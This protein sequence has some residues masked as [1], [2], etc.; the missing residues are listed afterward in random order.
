LG[1][2]LVF[3]DFTEQK[4]AQEQLRELSLLPTQNPAP[5]LRVADD[6]R[7]LYANLAALEH[8][9]DWNLSIGQPAPAEVR[10]LT[11]DALNAKHPADRDLTVG[12]RSYLISV[13]PI[14]ESRYANLYWTEVTERKKAVEA[15]RQAHG[16]LANHAVE[17]DNLVQQRT[18]KLQETVGEL[19]AFSYSIAHDM[20]GPLRAMQGFARV[21]VTDFGDRLDAEAR[22]YLQRIE[23][24]A[25]RMDRLITDILNYSKVV[26]GTLELK[27][28]DVEKLISEI[29]AS[30]PA[31]QREK[32]DIVVD[33]PLP[34]VLAN[35]AALT[36]VI[37]NLLGNAVKFVAPGVRPCVRM[38]GKANADFVELS[39]EDNGIGIA[40]ESHARLF[41]IFIR[42]NRPELYEGTGIGLAIVRK[43]VDRMGGAVGVESEEGKG[44]RFWVRLQKPNPS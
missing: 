11:I 8:L 29:I 10:S 3:R 13:A 32:A 19:E 38:S 9:R 23:Q 4:K 24:S 22:E 44:S 34:R 21:L 35:D 12:D 7:L 40:P 2:V 16:Q 36:Q 30:Y 15:L 41:N 18:A 20:R 37:S 6:G 42:L 25:N 1:V 14:P 5:I 17:L 31:L 39:F 28:I 33:S 26:R 43:A 27:S